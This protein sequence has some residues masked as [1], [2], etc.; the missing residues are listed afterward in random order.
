MSNFES[1]YDE[2]SVDTMLDS[3]EA[4][5]AGRRTEFKQSIMRLGKKVPLEFIKKIIIDVLE[6]S[7]IMSLSQ[8]GITTSDRK[9][10]IVQLLD[11]ITEGMNFNQR[12]IF[13]DILGELHEGYLKSNLIPAFND[14]AIAMEKLGILLGVNMSK[15]YQ[16]NM[17]S[18]RTFIIS[19]S[20]NENGSQFVM[21]NRFHQLVKQKEQ[22]LG[23][24]NSEIAPKTERDKIKRLITSPILTIKRYSEMYPGKMSEEDVEAFTD[25]YIKMICFDYI[26]NQTDRNDQNYGVLLD[27]NGRISFAPLIDTDYVLPNP[28]D[29]NQ[30][31][32][33]LNKK[34]N[35]NEAMSVLCE[36]YPQEVEDFMRKVNESKDTIFEILETY[37]SPDMLRGKGNY[38]SIISHNIQALEKIVS[39]RNQESP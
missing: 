31:P 38:V 6:L 36:L 1:I 3:I 24:Q 19:Q 12:V 5:D 28:S 32:F 39:N 15:V 18:D 22:E 26:I 4:L 23:L 27:A 33:S 14:T 17:D 20:V 8:T 7:E 34:Y 21:F 16:A 37:L 9:V 10:D 29:P 11:V 2:V 13:Q 25:E 35:K 30:L